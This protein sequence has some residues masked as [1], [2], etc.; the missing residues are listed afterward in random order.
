MFYIWLQLLQ[1]GCLVQQT[2]HRIA[3]W[4]LLQNLPHCIGIGHEC[5]TQLIVIYDS[6]QFI[7]IIVPTRIPECILNEN[8]E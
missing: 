7:H 2:K 5:L 4:L 3:T 6:F 8:T 1:V